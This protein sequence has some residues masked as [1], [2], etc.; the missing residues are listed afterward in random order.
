MEEGEKDRKERWKRGR[1]GGSEE[2]RKEERK[3]ERE[4]EKERGRKT[5]PAELNIT[6]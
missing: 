6:A 5:I 4:K 3:G 1:E 2:G